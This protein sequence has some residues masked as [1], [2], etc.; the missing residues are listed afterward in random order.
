MGVVG[1]KVV[2]GAGQP[3]AGGLGQPG[4]PGA[5]FGDSIG[6]R[7]A[8]LGEGGQ[9]LAVEVEGVG[10][11]EGVGEAQASAA[12]AE[13][14]A[15]FMPGTF[16]RYGANDTGAANVSPFNPVDAIMASGRYDCALS[17][18]LPALAG[19]DRVGL[20]LAAYNAGAGAVIHFGGI[21]LYPQTEAYV[22][23]DGSA[24]SRERRGIGPPRW[25]R[26]HDL[27]RAV[28]ICGLA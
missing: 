6:G 2:A 19:E 3:V 14:I 5:T 17:A 23:P 7:A 28:A 20:V 10:D 21:P 22:N 9:Y 26:C 8:N 4:P 11:D 1:L 27:P 16:A 18:S 13:G 12:G 24:R 25:R 15:Q